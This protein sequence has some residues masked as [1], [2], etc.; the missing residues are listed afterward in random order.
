MTDFLDT[1]VMGGGGLE[2]GDILPTVRNQLVDGRTLL[3]CDGRAILPGS[4]PKIEALIQ[5][6]LSIRDPEPFGI[7]FASMFKKA[8]NGTAFLGHNLYSSNRRWVYYPDI[9][10]PNTYSPIETNATPD[11]LVGLGD[12]S[13]DGSIA[14]IPIRENNTNYLQVYQWTGSGFTRRTVNSSDTTQ[15]RPAVTVAGDG[16]AAWLLDRSTGNG[17]SVSLRVHKSTNGG[18]NWTETF[19]AE[20]EVP[21]YGIYDA[22]CT[23][24][25]SLIAAVGYNGNTTHIYRSND[26]GITWSGQNVSSLMRLGNRIHISQTTGKIIVLRSGY[27]PYYLRSLDGGATFEKEFVQTDGIMSESTVVA[28]YYEDERLWFLLRGS[29]EG[30]E[31]SRYRLAY[32]DD[33]GDSWIYCPLFEPPVTPE[34]STIHVGSSEGLFIH[35]EQIS[36]YATPMLYHATFGKH[37]PQIPHNKIV[38][39]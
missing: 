13:D 6:T 22:D 28:A 32:S 10:D 21:V 2:A 12:M 18:T 14:I 9:A 29:V 11:Y 8:R 1:A 16:S 34:A 19:E 24:D 31:P 36:G 26:G 17:S 39:E 7:D 33:H 4:Y 25:G 3:P 35:G 38:A 23:Q 15:E 5:D 20:I 30:S 37:T 27:V